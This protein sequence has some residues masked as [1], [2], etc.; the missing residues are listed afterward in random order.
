M[1]ER[2]RI[3]LFTHLLNC[4]CLVMGIVLIGI[5]IGF[6]NIRLDIES[7]IKSWFHL[8]I[9]LDPESYEL[10]ELGRAVWMVSCPFAPEPRLTTG[11]HAIQIDQERVRLRSEPNIDTNAN[12]VGNIEQGT[13]LDVLSEPTCEDG[14][15]WY[16]VRTDD[17]KIGW[18]A[19]SK[20][21][22]KTYWLERADDGNECKLVPRLTVG[23]RAENIINVPVNLRKLPRIHSDEVSPD[24]YPG[25]EVE[26]L[27]GPVCADSFVWYRVRKN[28]SE[29]KVWVPEGG[30]D[31]D[32][33]DFL[34]WLAAITE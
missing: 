33:G 31:E 2:M 3:F 24:L 20:L 10:D 8:E 30:Q 11:D 12:I 28:N 18:A 19:E 14:Y 34:Y 16:N 21:D 1:S 25:K 23:D 32:S 5:F 29:K 13:W 7:L 27:A 6:E 9:T 26:V 15:Y 22:R 4:G 17:N